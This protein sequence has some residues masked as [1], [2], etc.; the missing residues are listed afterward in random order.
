MKRKV[1]RNL[2]PNFVSPTLGVFI[3]LMVFIGDRVK[4]KS[5]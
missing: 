2:G 4:Q 5:L 1:K 3:G